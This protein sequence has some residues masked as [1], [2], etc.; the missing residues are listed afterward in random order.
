MCKLV[1]LEMWM[2]VRGHLVVL[3]LISSVRPQIW[4]DR[5][6]WPLQVAQRFQC[7]HQGALLWRKPNLNHRH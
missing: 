1:Q 4:M 6:K 3:P 5:W 2:P 7:P